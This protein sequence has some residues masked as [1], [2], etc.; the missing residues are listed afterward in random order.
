MLSSI[1]LMSFGLVVVIVCLHSSG[2]VD[3][4]PAGK[5]SALVRRLLNEK[6]D[7]VDENN[8]ESV[9]DLFDEWATAH[10][11]TFADDNE[12]MD[13]LLKWRKNAL[14][15][16]QHRREH[17]N[18][19]HT[20]QLGLTKFA[21]M[22]IEEFRKTRLGYK[23]TDPKGSGSVSKSVAKATKN[24]K[25]KRQVTTLPSIV[26]WVTGGLVTSVKDQGNCG[27][28][29]A[30]S[31]AAVLEGAYSKAKGQLMDFSEEEFV[32][33]AVPYVG[34]DG[35]VSATAIEF[36]AAQGGVSTAA[37]YPYIA[38]DYEYNPQCE[39]G[40]SVKIPMTPSY[41]W[42]EDDESILQAVAD[43]P[44]AACVAV[45]D[46]FYL[47]ESGIMDPATSC[48]PEINHAILVVGYGVDP[49]SKVAYWKIKNSWAADWGENGY[50]RISRNVTNSCGLTVE[51]LKVDLTF[52]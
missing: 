14:R 8:E 4:N 30:F 9:Y 33:C 25:V 27:C 17:K 22:T 35:G 49:V 15:V 1:W 23:R 5:R 47:Y 52:P 42:L 44:V 39:V 36:V 32:D 46:A 51:A 50:F 7:S 43:Q 41:T 28:C 19:Q 2:V 12:R 26:D 31:A 48:D 34:C 10:D 29:W 38:Q 18:G 45:G 20:Y 24:K 11:L 40:S 13:A 37:S 16:K 3:S 21:G 6:L